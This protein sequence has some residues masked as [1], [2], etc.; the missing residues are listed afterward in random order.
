MYG[1]ALPTGEWAHLFPGDCLM[2]HRGRV[3]RPTWDGQPFDVLYLDITNAPVFRIAGQAQTGDN[4]GAPWRG[5]WEWT[6]TTGK[7]EHRSTEAPGTYPVMYDSTGALHIATSEHNGSQGWRYESETGELVTGDHSLNDQRSVG[8]A[9]GLSQ[10]W[11]YTHY[12][13]VTIGQGDNPTGAHVLIDGTRRLLEPGDCHFIRV[14]YDSLSGMYAVALTRLAEGDC[15]IEWMLKPQFLMLPVIGTAP[16]PQPQ[17]DPQQPTDPEPV[18]MPE[19]ENQSATVARVREKYPTPLGAKH[20]ACLLEIAREIGQGAGLLRK[21]G[22]T[23][24]ELPDGTR[25]AQ[26]IIVFPNGDGYDCLG[27]GETLATPQWSGPV[28]GSPFPSSRYYKVSASAPPVDPEPQP[29]PNPDTGAPAWARQLIADVA[30]IRQH[31][32]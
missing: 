3:E 21:D 18:P 5:T 14:H 30:A 6:S 16:V 12:N 31:F 9:L 27:S 19:I 8:L 28:E 22:G 23:N 2:T 13:G 15:R 7:W 24:I 11:E 29:Q 17:P 32:R 1:V 26:D 20:A 4:G 25:V 10:L